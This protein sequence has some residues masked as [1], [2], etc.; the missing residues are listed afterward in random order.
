[1]MAI[2]KGSAMVVCSGS[3]EKCKVPAAHAFT[4]RAFEVLQKFLL[5]AHLNFNMVRTWRYVGYAYLVPWAKTNQDHFK[6]LRISLRPNQDDDI[7]HA[8][9]LSTARWSHKLKNQ[10]ESKASNHKE[11]SL[12]N[13]YY[14]K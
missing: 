1:M 7:S 8:P 12:I 4:I 9:L 10:T 5:R 14:A 2:V 6:F 11:Q 3:T 13:K